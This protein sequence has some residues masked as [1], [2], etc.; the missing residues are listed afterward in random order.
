MEGKG[1]RVMNSRQTQAKLV[2]SNLKKNSIAQ[3]VEHLF[4]Q[5]M[6]SIPSTEKKPKQTKN[7]TVSMRLL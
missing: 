7:P 5:A 6:G 1:R 2:S 3:V 4:S